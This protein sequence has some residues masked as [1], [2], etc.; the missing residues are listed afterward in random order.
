MI[1]KLKTNKNRIYRNRDCMIF[2]P[3]DKMQLC[4]FCICFLLMRY[5]NSSVLFSYLPF[6]ISL[7]MYIKKCKH[8]DF[9]PL[10]F[11]DFNIVN[12]FSCYLILKHVIKMQHLSYFIVHVHGEICYKS[13][14]ERFLIYY[15][16]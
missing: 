2:S 11:L 3:R 1:R 4:N 12:S 14:Y 10:L 8:C 7:S 5:K 9:L 13:I 15:F 6:Y 16:K